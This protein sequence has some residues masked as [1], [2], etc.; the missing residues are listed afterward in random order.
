MLEKQYHRK[1]ERGQKGERNK[2]II[3]LRASTV[4]EAGPEGAGP[5]GQ[6]S[7]SGGPYFGLFIF[8][9]TERNKMTEVLL[10]S[11]GYRVGDRPVVLESSARQAV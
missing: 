6:R 8:G 10:R 5:S 9:P 11:P 1:E 7:G 4:A 3:L 2:T